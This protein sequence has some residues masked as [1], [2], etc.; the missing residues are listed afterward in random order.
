[1]I[2]VYLKIINDINIDFDYY[3]FVNKKAIDGKKYNNIKEYDLFINEDDSIHIYKDNNWKDK[4]KAN[5]IFMFMHSLDL[6]FGNVMDDNNLPIGI[7]K[8]LNIDNSKEVY[9]S[10]IIYIDFAELKVWQKFAYLQMSL[11]S[12]L[13]A[14]I[15]FLLFNSLFGHTLLSTIITIICASLLWVIMKRKLDAKKRELYGLMEVG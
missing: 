11:V 5:R 7:D 9:I 3:V 1:M 10:D 12:I 15:M 13:T 4:S 2:K 6:M 14:I 8:T